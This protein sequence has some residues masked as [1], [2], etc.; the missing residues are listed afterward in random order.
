[1]IHFYKRSE[2]KMTVVTKPL[3]AAEK[4]KEAEANS[5]PLVQPQQDVAVPVPTQGKD[6][7]DLRLTYLNGRVRRMSRANHLC[8]ALCLTLV[9]ML[10]LMAAMHIYKTLFI[11]RNFCGSY[12]IPLNHGI[13]PENTLVAANFQ[14]PRDYDDAFKLNMFALFNHEVPKIAKEVQEQVKDFE[15]DVE[16]DMDTND[17]ETF[18][19][20]EI[21]LG[22]YMHDFKVNYT[23]IIDTLGKKCFLMNLDRNLIPAPKNVFDILAKMRKGAFDIDYEEIKKTYRVN[24]PALAQFDASHGSFI[25]DACSNKPTY[26]LE[27]LVGNVV[28][29]REVTSGNKFGEFVGSKLIKYNIVNAE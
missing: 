21:F 29:K 28:V 19:M 25:P 26:R 10:G 2:R 23:V 18:E 15:F 4:K 6:E 14:N 24:G 13:M 22:R 8:L 9:T 7:P 27:E 12:R 3:T 20:P 1:L 5:S 17:F 16:L 11:R